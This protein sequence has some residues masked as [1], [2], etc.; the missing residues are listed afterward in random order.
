MA[1]ISGVSIPKEKRVV[2]SLTYV[3]GIGP[4]LSKKILKEA[5]IDEAKRVKDLTE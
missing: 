2:V 5:K 1:R 4:A 3:F